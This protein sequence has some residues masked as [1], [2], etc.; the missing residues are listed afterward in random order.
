MNDAMLHLSLPVKD[1]AEARSFYTAVFGCRTGRAADTWIDIWFYGMQLTLQHRPGEVRMPNDQGVL[2]FGVVMPTR[3]AFDSVM[4]RADA[5]GVEWVERPSFKSEPELSG[6]LGGKFADPSG[7]V[8][9][10]K[11]YEDAGA[12]SADEAAPEGGA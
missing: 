10:V 1:L 3:M 2:H 4:E 12:L 7:N 11:F 6:K 5:F 9:E 8:I